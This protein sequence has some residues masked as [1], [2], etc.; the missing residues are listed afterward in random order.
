MKILYGFSE[1]KFRKRRDVEFWSSVWE[2][3][4]FKFFNLVLLLV[5]KEGE[6][7]KVRD[8]F[9]GRKRKVSGSII[10]K[11]L[12]VMNVYEFKEVVGF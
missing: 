4:R 1:I 3:I 11:E 8:F 6:M 9:I 10:R 5:F 7:G 12:D 2:G